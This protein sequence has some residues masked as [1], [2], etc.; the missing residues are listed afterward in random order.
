[1]R[2]S[3]LDKHNR[4][5]K[6]LQNKKEI[7][8][9][10]RKEWELKLIILKTY[11]PFFNLKDSNKQKMETSKKLLY[12]S[13]AIAI[14]LSILVVKCTFSGIECSNLLSITVT[15]WGEVATVNTF[16]LLM[17][18]K[19][20]APKVLMHIYNGLPEKIKEQIDINSLLSNVMN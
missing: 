12:V 4:T 14:T 17:N 11:L 18:K 15:S 13:Y 5:M 1:M 16:Y 3:R 6:R 9:L 10:R 19:L 20:N 2:K 8:E 7:A